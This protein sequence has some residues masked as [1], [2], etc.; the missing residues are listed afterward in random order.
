MTVRLLSLTVLLASFLAFPALAQTEFPTLDVPPPPPQTQSDAPQGEDQ[1]TIAAVVDGDAIT[2]ADVNE[3]LKLIMS[4]SGMPDTPEMRAKAV[5]QVIS[6]LVDETVIL[7][8]AKK[9]GITVSDQDVQ[10]GFAELAAQN[11]MTADQFHDVLTKS[12]IP[13]KA[14]QDQIKGQLA[15]TKII[16]KKIRPQIEITDRQIDSELAKAKANEGTPEYLLA[17]IYLP[18]ET[19][20]AE[21]QVHQL[22]DKITAGL[23]AGKA[24]FSAI[25]AQFSQS[26][27]ASKGGD[28]G[29]VLRGQLP[30]QVDEVVGQ[31]TPG[32]LSQ[33]IRTLSGYYI[34][35]LRQK[36]EITPETLP[37]RD[38]I[39]QQIG[40]S[41]LD[42]MQRRYLLDLKSAA[43][44]DKR[45]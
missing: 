6:M 17:E 30:T 21:G 22:A 33:P 37:S 34:V 41:E 9:D 5:P 4:S 36:R 16:Q 32:Q 24:P 19:P 26:A 20:Q 12:N 42:R 18:V 11:K 25:A 10:Q 43:F 39:R 13:A 14:L 15:W 8:E 1:A 38:D 27:S 31:M 44:I 40:M 28:M 7:Q 45:V 35:L 29:W 23:S 2:M 3:R